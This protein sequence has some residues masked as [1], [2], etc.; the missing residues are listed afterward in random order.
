MESTP[1]PVTERHPKLYKSTVLG[2]D[3]HRK[4]Q[5]LLGMLQWMVTIGK[6]K[7]CQV[8]SSLDC[9]GTCPREGHLY[10]A[11]RAFGYV[12]TTLNKQIPIDSIGQ[13]N[14]KDLNQMLRG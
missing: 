8:V 2:I 3:D 7:L 5:M 13:C 9:F 6:P 10:L 11:V 4:F 14:S 12:K 1:L